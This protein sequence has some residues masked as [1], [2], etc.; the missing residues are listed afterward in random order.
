MEGR[1]LCVREIDRTNELVRERKRMNTRKCER[2]ERRKNEC[3]CI[4]GRKEE[5]K[6]TRHKKLNNCLSVGR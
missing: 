6:R 5:K 3:A 2:E 1:I 4:N